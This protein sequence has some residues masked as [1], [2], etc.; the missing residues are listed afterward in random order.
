MS[1]GGDPNAWVWQLV[2]RGKSATKCEGVLELVLSR[3]TDQRLARARCLTSNSTQT[4]GG[5]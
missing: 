2:D 5:K 3:P 1:E 4:D